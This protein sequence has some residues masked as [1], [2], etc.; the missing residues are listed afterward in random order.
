MGAVVSG[1]ERYDVAVV[2]AGGAGLAAAVSARED[3]ASVI[4]V[5]R[6]LTS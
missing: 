2:G 1:D 6:P 4:L 5:G 3:G